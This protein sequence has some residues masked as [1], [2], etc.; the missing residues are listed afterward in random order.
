MAGARG[1]DD[2]SKFASFDEGA[3][4]RRLKGSV[5]R[6]R[7]RPPQRKTG[8]SNNPDDI[9]KQIGAFI[10]ARSTDRFNTQR[11]GE[12]KWTPR[13]TPHVIG[14]VTDIEQ[15]GKA[16]AR[17][18]SD[19]PALI[20]TGRLKGSISWKI[21]GPREVEA[22]TNLP[23]A[24]DQQ[25]G[26]KDN[27]IPITPRVRE[28]ITELIKDN[29]ELAKDLSFLLTVDELKFDIQPRKFV[30]LDKRDRKDLE[31]LVQGQISG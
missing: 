25:F 20:D 21:T 17:R 1:N 28:G 5:G 14:I 18:F 31:T 2:G 19:G 27:V 8:K 29:P 6:G 15:T 16:K 24:P 22:G 30:G 11:F 12:K 26:K 4:L 9:L 3:R 13:G 7:G 23:Y 10:T